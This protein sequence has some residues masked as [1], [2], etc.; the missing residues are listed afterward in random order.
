[1]TSIVPVFL[2]LSFKFYPSSGLEFYFFQIFPPPI[3]FMD[4][5]AG[6]SS[7]KVSLGQVVVIKSGA[8]NDC[9]EELE[10]VE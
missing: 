9:E 8:E 3:S 5:W 7:N 6:L 1:M 4:E 10:F 2:F